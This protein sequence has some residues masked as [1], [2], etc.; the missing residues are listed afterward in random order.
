MLG[1]NK[2]YEHNFKK[3]EHYYYFEIKNSKDPFYSEMQFLQEGLTTT[4]NLVKGVIRKHL[5]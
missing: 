4:L 5:E 2:K 3:H 1:L